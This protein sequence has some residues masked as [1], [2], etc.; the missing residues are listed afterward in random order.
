MLSHRLRMFPK[1]SKNRLA[2]RGRLSM[3]FYSRVTT[4]YT[5]VIISD[6]T[7]FTDS[8]ARSNRPSDIL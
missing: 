3:L 7:I 5:A 8:E 1:V 2:I 6:H 4:D